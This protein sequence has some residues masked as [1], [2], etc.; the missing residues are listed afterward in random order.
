MST[1]ELIRIGDV[2]VLLPGIHLTIYEDKHPLL[3]RSD[4]PI[5]LNRHH[6]RCASGRLTAI[7]INSD[8]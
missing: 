6:G 7:V 1:R 5:S 8:D 2:T 3:K 4:P